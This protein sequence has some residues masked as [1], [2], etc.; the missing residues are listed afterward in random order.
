MEQTDSTAT[1]TDRRLRVL[2]A[3]DHPVIRKSVRS[4]LEQYPRYEIIGEAVDGAKAIEEAQRLKPDVIVLNV[5]MPVL[6][7]LEAAREI[8]MKVPHSAIVMLS[9][10]ADER[11]IQEAKK[12][13]VGAYVVKSRAAE[14]L[15]KAIEAA[16]GGGG[17][18]SVA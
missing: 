10:N 1:P 17:F 18:V 4:I 2:I 7:G 16:I 3:D 9:L 15:V 13:C 6:N 14:T 5:N 12:I 8:N 11:L